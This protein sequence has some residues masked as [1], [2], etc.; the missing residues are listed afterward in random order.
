MSF[1][2][3]SHR[4]VKQFMPYMREMLRQVRGNAEGV[5][6]SHYDATSLMHFAGNSGGA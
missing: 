6:L 5:R 1:E 3:D 2:Y 4:N